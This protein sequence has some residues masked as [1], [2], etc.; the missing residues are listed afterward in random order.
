[1]LA[2]HLSKRRLGQMRDIWLAALFG[3]RTSFDVSR[4][5]EFPTCAIITPG[6]TADIRGPR[7]ALTDGGDTNS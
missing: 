2:F 4:L 3:T 7:L 5:P 1:M 6:I